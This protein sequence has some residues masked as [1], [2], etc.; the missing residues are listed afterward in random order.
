MTVTVCLV[1][2]PSKMLAQR[3]RQTSN[4]ADGSRTIT[5][6]IPSVGV[7][8]EQD[9]DLSSHPRPVLRLRGGPRTQRSVA[10][11]D[12]VVDNENAGKKK[13][14]SEFPYPGLRA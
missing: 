11:K 1:P 5:I 12:S 8:D 10:W 6:E 2:P 9:D 4:A 13:S 3:P 14:K 7:R